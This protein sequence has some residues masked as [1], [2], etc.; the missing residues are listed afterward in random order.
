MARARS[1][2]KKKVQRA[3]PSLAQDLTKAQ[4]L[5][6]QFG[7]T[8]PLSRLDTSQQEALASP[9][10]AAF[11]GQR[12]D[13]TKNYLEALQNQAATAGNRSSEMADILALMR[14][15]LAGLN[16]QENTAIREQ[17]QR[18]LDRRF[19]NEQYA[20]QKAAG[21]GRLRGGA[22][23]S[24][25]GDIGQRAAESQS[26]LEQD[27]LVK[28]IDIQD[29]RRN[30]Y[31]SFLGGQEEAERNRTANALGALGAGIGGAEQAEF[32][33]AEQARQDLLGAQNT[34]LNQEAR[35]RAARAATLTGLTGI[36]SGRR[37]LRK[38]FQLAKQ[39]LRRG[40]GRSGGGNA[41]LAD[42]YGKILDSYYGS[43][44]SSSI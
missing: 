8:E 39:G 20:L 14:N 3:E 18:E 13:Q 29:Q 6:T 2:R 26:Q 43:G 1:R 28:N 42:A 40:D 23:A 36:Q 9:T 11:A 21:G 31:G 19:Q 24:S 17:A 16:A 10:S 4:E 37:S 12:S 38:Q 7:L 30:Q 5:G 33:R 44:T 15:G 32:Q 35:D 27:L 22:L 34:N 25:L 41:G